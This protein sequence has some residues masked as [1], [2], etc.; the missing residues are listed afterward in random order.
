MRS[1]LALIWLLFGLLSQPLFAQEPE[2]VQPPRSRVELLAGGDLDEWIFYTADASV[3]KED[4]CRLEDG[5]LRIAGRPAGYLQTRR[6]YRDYVLEVEWRWPEGSRGGNSGVLVHTT[7]PLLFFGWPRSLE[8]QLAHGQA[9]D[10]WV[11]GQEVDLRVENEANRRVEPRPGD[12][13]SHRRIRRLAEDVE[14]PIGRWNLLRVVCRGDEVRVEVNGQTVNHGTECTVQEGAI[15]L[16]SEGAPIEFRR[17]TIAP[18]PEET[19]H[20]GD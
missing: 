8:V 14:K 17:V 3:R 11:I 5:I 20:D 6:W 13:H 10:F 1:R 18:L 12:Q 16:Q 19:E 7:A 2:T 9:G 15:A 4:V